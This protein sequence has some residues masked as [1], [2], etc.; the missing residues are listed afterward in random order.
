VYVSSTMSPSIQIDLA[1]VDK[2]Q[3]AER[4]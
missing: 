4:A 1:D 3:Q 2:L